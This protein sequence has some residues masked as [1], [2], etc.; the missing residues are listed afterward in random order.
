MQNL[1]EVENTFDW[2]S[3]PFAFRSD[4][5]ESYGSVGLEYKKSLRRFRLELVENWVA[6]HSNR[7]PVR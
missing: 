3:N 5:N 7:P 1:F 2:N 6:I 4:S